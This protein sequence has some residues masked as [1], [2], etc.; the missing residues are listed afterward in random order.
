[1]AHA[2]K[3]AEHIQALARKEARIADLNRQLEEANSSSGCCEWLCP[4][5]DN[6]QR[7]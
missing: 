3:D 5:K 1:M 6:K 4:P 2:K 7:P